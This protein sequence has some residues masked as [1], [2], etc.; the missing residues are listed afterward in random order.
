MTDHSPFGAADDPSNHR[1][2]WRE[3]VA[4]IARATFAV[5]VGATT[6]W[7]TRDAGLGLTAAAATVSILREAFVQPTR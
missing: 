7:I 4:G 2:R 3:R 6:G 1:A 5:A